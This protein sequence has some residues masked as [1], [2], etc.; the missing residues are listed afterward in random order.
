M[1]LAAFGSGVISPGT[2][3]Q[4]LG[5]LL[6]PVLGL[7][8]LILW[9]VFFS[10][11]SWRERLT[12]LALLVVCLVA[13]R[14]LAHPS[15][16]QAFVVVGIPLLSLAAIAWLLLARRFD[17]RTRQVGAVVVVVL[18]CGAWTLIR[19]EGV[20]G[21]LGT[22]YAWRWSSTTEERFLATDAAKAPERSAAATAGDP[23]MFE[24]A[25]WPGFRGPRRDSRVEGR[26]IG[27]SWE[28]EP[29]REIWRRAIGP[30]WS[31]FAVVGDRLYTQE[32]RGEEEV[33]SCYDAETGEPLWL[34]GNPAR[35]WEALA[36]AGPRATPTFHEGRIYATG[37]T[38]IVDCLDAMSGE[39]I[40]SRD[41][42]ADTGAELPD[43][44]FSS[45]PLVV[46]GVVVVYS[47]AAEGKAIV[48]YDVEDGEPRWFVATGS[49]SYSSPHLATLDGVEQ[50]LMLT[51]A[52]AIA[53]DPGNGAVLWEHAWPLKGSSRIVQPLITDDRRVLIGTGFGYGVRS[54][55]V[56]WNGSSWE[57]EEGWTSRNLK[58][59]FNDMV[60]HRGH[61]FGFDG[62][63]LAC[64]DATTGARKWKKGRYGNGQV[65]LIVEQDLLL[66]LSESGEIVLVDADPERFREVARMPAVEGKT[67]NHPVIAEDRLYVRN[68]AEAVAYGLPP[69]GP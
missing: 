46:D 69:A 55:R 19:T 24:Q 13:M 47:G 4:F 25:V 29:P 20:D 59:Y 57:V 16:T 8:L 22:D 12:G 45:S 6:G 27:T 39:L 43:W 50:V 48:A 17:T 3:V 42:V 49:L 30:G 52:G 31:S 51:D 58:P 10:R 11:A 44:G 32:Q 62:N 64:I 61:L 68:G 60:A 15:A 9:W 63:I 41:L 7:S 37:A 66:V 67:W 21:T 36:G 35:F 38:G 18:A 26:T 56:S 14:S 53:I 2:I 65:L 34:H 40:W 23:L 5:M 28:V 1:W 54:L 33:V